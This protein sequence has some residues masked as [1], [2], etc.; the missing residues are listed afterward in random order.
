MLQP[1]SQLPISFSTELSKS[2]MT[3]RKTILACRKGFGT[4][5][6][7]NICVYRLLVRASLIVPVEP[8][9]AQSG[10]NSKYRF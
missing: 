10:A 9:R 8:R 5:S 1:V 6:A 3:L 7:E 2:E 4:L